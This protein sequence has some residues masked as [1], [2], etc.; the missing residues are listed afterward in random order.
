M[1]KN[2]KIYWNYERPTR[3]VASVAISAGVGLVLD[4]S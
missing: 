3:A 4:T 1:A 2:S